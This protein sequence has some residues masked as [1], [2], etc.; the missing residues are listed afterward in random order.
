[1]TLPFAPAAE[2]NRE[3]ILSVLREILPERGRVLEVA[4]GTGQHVVHF[5]R[6]FPGITW[7]PSDADPQQR[8]AIATRGAESALPNLAPPQVLDTRV[9]PWSVEPVDAVVCINMVHISPWEATLGLLEETARLLVPGGVLFFYGP[10][11]WA[12]QHT[13]PSNAAFDLDLRRRDP[14]WGV[15]DLEEVI[16]AAAAVGLQFER[17]VAMPAN[18]FSVVFRARLG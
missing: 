6:A 5:A 12:G 8:D 9:R 15:R 11:R 2:R 14:A 3:P 10:Y 13:A 4:S 17:R 7:Q 1:M 16:D 18:N